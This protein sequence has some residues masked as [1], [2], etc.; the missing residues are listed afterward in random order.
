MPSLAHVPVLALTCSRP[1]S[2]G[3]ADI[4]TAVAVVVPSVPSVRCSDPDTMEFLSQKVSVGAC[5]A[6]ISG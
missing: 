2:C 1:W 3:C 5:N 4:D 6:H